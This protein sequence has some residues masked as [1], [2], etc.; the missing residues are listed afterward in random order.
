M[1]TLE[2]RVIISISPILADDGSLLI[3]N[4][5]FSE[6]PVGQNIMQENTAQKKKWHLQSLYA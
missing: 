1:H 6:K 2:E 3:K 5:N 4:D